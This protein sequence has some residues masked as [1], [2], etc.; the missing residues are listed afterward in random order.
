MEKEDQRVMLTKKLL[1][2]S[3][4]SL[5]KEKTIFRITIRELC[6]TAGINRS[7]FYKYY[8]SQ[9]DLLQEMEN[10]ILKRVN[11]SLSLMKVK[12]NSDNSEM[13]KVILY[14]LE[15]NV[16]FSR[17]LVNNNVDPEFP[18]KLINLPQI[19]SYISNQLQSKYTESQIDYFSAFITYGGYQII[20]KWINKDQREPVSE[21]AF[22]LNE[23]FVGIM[24]N[25]S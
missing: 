17:L 1:K 7:T 12:E 14:L 24:K 3:L 10:Q 4:V 25:N 20:Q 8:G 13:L 21:M 22:I 5:L 18:I 19:H 23:F 16:E 11:Y 2:D 6:D 9:F 15:E